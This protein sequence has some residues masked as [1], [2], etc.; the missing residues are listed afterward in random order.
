LPRKWQRFSHRQR[1]DR[2]GR[3]AEAAGREAYIRSRVVLVFM[4]VEIA[5]LLMIGSSFYN[6]WAGEQIEWLGIWSHDITAGTTRS[7]QFWLLGFPTI[8]YH[9][10]LILLSAPLFYLLC[11]FK[12]EPALDLREHAG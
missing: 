10:V 7:V 3:I 4:V 5:L 8:I 11:H 12:E 9:I 6:L 1:R 2:F